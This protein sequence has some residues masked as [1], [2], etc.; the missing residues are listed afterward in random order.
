MAVSSSFN[1]AIS[2]LF[3][4]ILSILAGSVIGVVNDGFCGHEFQEIVTNPKNECGKAKAKCTF[5]KS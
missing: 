3:L 5:A 2:H 1:C 4:L